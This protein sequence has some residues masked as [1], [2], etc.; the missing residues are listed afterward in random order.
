MTAARYSELLKIIPENSMDKVKQLVEEVAFIEGQ[1][2]ELKKLPFIQVNPKNP[3]QQR[4]T[5]AAKQYKELLQQY[6]N[7]LKLLL[8]VCGDIGGDDDEESPLRKWVRERSE[9]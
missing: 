4:T 8:K 6:N 9:A 3:A 2:V 1:L 7:S 5:A